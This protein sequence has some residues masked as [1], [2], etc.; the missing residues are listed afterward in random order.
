M[1]TRVY[2]G[3]LGDNGNQQ[4][5]ED[6]FKS[7]GPLKEVWIAKEPKGFAFVEFN[8]SEDAAT[9]IKQLDGTSVCGC[10]VRV[11]MARDSRRGR[12]GS[13]GGR[14]FYPRSSYRHESPTSYGSRS[15]RDDR[16]PRGSSFRDRDVGYS[17][18]DYSR[19]GGDYAR[20]DSYIGSRRDVYTSPPSRDSYRTRSDYEGPRG[21]D[22]YYE[23][24]TYR[25]GGGGGGGGSY[26][27][28]VN[29]Y[30]NKSRD[31]SPTRR[32][33]YSYGSGPRGYVGAAPSFRDEQHASYDYDKSYSRK[34]DYYGGGSMRNGDR[35]RY[36]RS[37]ARSPRKSFRDRSPY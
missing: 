37:P 11:E 34:D 28:S 13:R 26:T 32:D 20:V 5:L 21:A 16:G 9:A 27:R 12:G 25:S 33:D 4:E 23:T 31:Y 18:K 22:P 7:F 10:K 8:Y 6:V 30:D 29:T 19:S 24:S 17:D 36:G 14:G 1:A 15:R 2:V 35:T 3:D